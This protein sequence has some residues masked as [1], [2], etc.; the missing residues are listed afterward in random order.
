MYKI[1]FKEEHS[2]AQ[3]K[4]AA[5]TELDKKK[6]AL[7]EKNRKLENAN[8]QLQAKHDALESTIRDIKSNFD[9]GKVQNINNLRLTINRSS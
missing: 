4:D 7:E 6:S 2:S 3:L 5:I 9:A 8:T 1:A